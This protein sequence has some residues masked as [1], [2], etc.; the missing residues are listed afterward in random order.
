MPLFVYLP[1][2]NTKD[3]LLIISDHCRQVRD[4][5]QLHPKDVAPRGLRDGLQVSLRLEK[6]FD[7]ISRKYQFEISITKVGRQRFIRF[8]NNQHRI[9][10]KSPIHL[11]K[12][13]IFV[14]LPNYRLIHPG[15]C[16][17]TNA[18]ACKTT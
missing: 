7:M 15:P 16:F 5:C 10:A 2:R 6:S 3:C 14:S 11:T 8:S 4:L 12:E 13:S 9:M 18:H 17:R 1:H